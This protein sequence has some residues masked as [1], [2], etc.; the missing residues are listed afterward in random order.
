MSY[1]DLKITSK[2]EKQSGSATRTLTNTDCQD[3]LTHNTIVVAH[4]EL[5]LPVSTGNTE[6]PLCSQGIM[7]V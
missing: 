2:N 3:G 6:V 5:Y 7:L 1:I 4:Q